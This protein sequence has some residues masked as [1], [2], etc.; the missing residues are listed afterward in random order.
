MADGKSPR[1][2]MGTRIMQ[3]NHYIQQN[4]VSFVQEIVLRMAQAMSNLR[5]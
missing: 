4:Q 1:V 3:H 2:F 5:S